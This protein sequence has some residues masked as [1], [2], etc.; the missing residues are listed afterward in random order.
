MTTNEKIAALELAQGELCDWLDVVTYVGSDP[1]IRDAPH[2]NMINGTKNGQEF[3][4]S[5]ILAD[6]KRYKFCVV[7]NAKFPRPEQILTVEQFHSWLKEDRS[8]SPLL[9]N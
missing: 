1:Q 6:N 2:Y 8:Y 5:F 3:S 7:I 9:Q 4:F